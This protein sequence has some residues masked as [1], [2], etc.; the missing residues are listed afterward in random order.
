VDSECIDET[1]NANTPTAL[2]WTAHP[3]R[4]RPG[5]AVVVVAVIAFL[6]AAIGGFAGH[7]WVGVVAAVVLCASLHRFF[8]ASRHGIDSSGVRS[9]TLVGSRSLRWSEIRR[10]D[11]G[12]RGAW[13]CT[14]GRKNWL[15]SRRGVHVLYGTQRAAVRE[16]LTSARAALAERDAVPNQSSDR[17]GV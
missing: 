3:A 10:I 12:S 9:S 1:D 14:F 16:R 8:F 7:A 11:L 4:E 15:E 5:V 2:C 13:I 17:E 6:S